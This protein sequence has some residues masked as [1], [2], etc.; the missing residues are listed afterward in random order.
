MWNHLAFIMLLNALSWV[1]G[2]FFFFFWLNCLY[3]TTSCPTMSYV[4]FGDIWFL[5]LQAS[6]RS[7]RA[8]Y[9]PHCRNNHSDCPALIILAGSGRGHP[10]LLLPAG[11]YNATAGKPEFI[12]TPPHPLPSI[13]E[14]LL[15]EIT[16]QRPLFYSLGS[17][18]KKNGGLSHFLAKW[19]LHVE[20]KC[21]NL[22]G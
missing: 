3:L 9:S 1:A 17:R 8:G 11:L 2:F 16:L 7:F 12:P 14:K 10:L 5:Q 13:F 22:P 18:L 4:Y 21:Q 15:C 19:F 6:F 20:V